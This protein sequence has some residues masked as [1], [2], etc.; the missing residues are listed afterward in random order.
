MPG[1][2]RQVAPDAGLRLR[3]ERHGFFRLALPGLGAA[4][5][6]RFIKY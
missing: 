3:A 6:I 2:T 4:G 1:T 5:L